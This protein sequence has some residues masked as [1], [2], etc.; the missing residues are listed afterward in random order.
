MQHKN[1]RL[2][3]PASILSRVLWT[4]G[5]MQLLSMFGVEQD[6]KVMIK[7]TTEETY[8]RWNH[9]GDM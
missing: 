8:S 4:P 2:M 7:N 5:I 9:A 3:A 6:I 1:D